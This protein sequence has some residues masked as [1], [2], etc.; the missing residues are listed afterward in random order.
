VK[1]SGRTERSSRSH[2]PAGMTTTFMFGSYFILSHDA[3]DSGSSFFVGF[4]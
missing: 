3:D 2:E 4:V 1:R